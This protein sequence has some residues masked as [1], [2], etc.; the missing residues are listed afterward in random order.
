MNDSLQADV[1]EIEAILR[2]IETAENTGRFADIAA[3]L[4]ED[5]VIMVPSYPVQE[6][7]AACAAFV[8]SVLTDVLNEFDRRIVYVSA[9]VRVMGDVGLDRGT[10]SFTVS[11][12][13]GGETTLETGKYLFLYARSSDRSWKL[14]RVIVCLD[15]REMDEME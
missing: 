8:C 5:A 15:E 6:G 4:A 12:K 1:V 2:R 13:T 11:P 14:A 7:R 3:L 9:E 10:F